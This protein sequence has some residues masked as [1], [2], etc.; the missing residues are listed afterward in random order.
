M[1]RVRCVI[2][3]KTQMTNIWY[4]YKLHTKKNHTNEQTATSKTKTKTKKNKHNKTNNQQI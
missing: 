4:K 2:G 3:R 1:K